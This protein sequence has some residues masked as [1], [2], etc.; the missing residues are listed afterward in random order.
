MSENTKRSRYIPVEVR[1]ALLVE[2]RGR[3]C[4]CREAIPPGS[5]RHELLKDVLEKHHIVYFSEGG[6]QK[7]ENLAVI[8][9]DCH[10]LEQKFPE[11][12]TADRFRKAKEHWI[13]LASVV[14]SDVLYL[15]PPPQLT[16]GELL[17]L[18]RL[19]F[20][21]ERYGLDFVLTVPDSIRIAVLLEFLWRQ[22]INPI[23]EFDDDPYL[24]TR[25][26][27]RLSHRANTKDTF[28]MDALLTD[29]SLESDDALVVHYH[30]PGV[31]EPGPT[32]RHGRVLRVMP[33]FPRE[34]EG[35]DVEFRTEPEDVTISFAIEV[36]GT[37]G[38][39]SLRQGQTSQGRAT[40]RVPGAAQG[41]RDSIVARGEFPTLRL[42][43]VFGQVIGESSGHESS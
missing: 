15:G 2:S 3:C 35:Y 18:I 6:E 14:E 20:R 13:R 30:M 10:R 27:L 24:T 7:I 42:E 38:Y 43:L 34:R 39:H 12:Y 4:L 22:V 1:E 41:V 37:D 8:C 33:E 23:G 36:N 5:E 26:E 32:T 40:L 11:R 9:P 19:P 29:I 28:P 21:L 16:T 17:R 25:S 31:A